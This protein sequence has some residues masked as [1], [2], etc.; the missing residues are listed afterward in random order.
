MYLIEL[1]VQ[2]FP[3]LNLFG[4]RLVIDTQKKTNIDLNYFIDYH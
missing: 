3:T 2:S 4:Y 1:Y